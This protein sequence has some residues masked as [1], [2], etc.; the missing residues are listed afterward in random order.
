MENTRF[1]N[2]RYLL[3]FQDSGHYHLRLIHCIMRHLIL[4]LLETV[5]NACV[6]QRPNPSIKKFQGCAR[7]MTSSANSK[8]MVGVIQMTSTPNKEDTFKQA[9]ELIQRAKDEGA[10]VNLDI[11]MCA[12]AFTYHDIAQVK[13]ESLKLIDKFMIT[14]CSIV[15]KK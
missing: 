1:N 11:N 6:H 2:Y 7:D 12:L 3:L 10:Q 8:A 4:P 5:C 9:A 15:C 14:T 13:W